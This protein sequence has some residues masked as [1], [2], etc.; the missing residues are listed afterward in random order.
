VHHKTDTTV[1]LALLLLG[2]VAGVGFFSIPVDRENRSMRSTH[3][4]QAAAEALRDKTFGDEQP[5]VFML[6]PL[7]PGLI[8]PTDDPDV[9]PWIEKIR[10]LAWVK[11]ASVLPQSDAQAFYL[12]VLIRGAEE[13]RYFDRVQGT[14]DYAWNHRP[15]GYHLH[16]TGQALGEM[17]ISRAMDEE[18]DRIIPILLGALFLL[19]LAAY[20]RV[21]LA[22][23]ILASALLSILVLGGIQWVIGMQID[24]I[25]SL[26]PPVLL[27]VG[28]AGSVHLIE[29]F[30]EHRARGQTA[31]E[32]TRRAVRD[33]VRPALLTV[34]TT[35]A[36]FLGLLW[37]LIPAVR[38]FGLLAGFGVA[39]T[40]LLTF[41]WLPAYLRVFGR[42]ASLADLRRRNAGWSH[43]S[44]G[45]ALLL[46]HR[47]RIVALAGT[48]LVL[49]F[50]WQWS[51]IAVD[52]QPLRLLPTHNAF[53]MDTESVA[54]SLG[55]IE[56][57]DV[58]LPS[59][60]KGHP[61]RAYLDL[62]RAMHRE[63]LV[64]DLIGLPETAPTGAVR[65]HVLLR[66]AGTGER[67]RLFTRIEARARDLGWPQAV[68]AGAPVIVARD[69]NGLVD[70]QLE[71]MGF[72]LIFL[73]LA[74]S[75]GFRS[76]KY[77]VLGLIPN[78]VP[79][80]FLYGG[81]AF[82]G[83]PLSEG[84]AMIGSVLL[85][86]TVDDS[87]H[88]LYRY[89]QARHLGSSPLVST[90]RSFRVAG[91]A[92]LITTLVQAFGFLVCIVGSLAS[93]REFAILSSSTMIVALAAD[94]FLLPALLLLSRPRPAL[95]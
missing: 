9:P 47:A 60:L 31:E 43:L 37:S 28:V 93:S 80:I 41:L 38:H 18:V 76:L 67:A 82:V 87:I 36:G 6:K 74:M 20:R 59:G 24:P 65:Q 40:C 25:S 23:G 83:R 1:L 94:V 45:L 53:R 21:V 22:V 78:L 64:A 79:A 5:L 19:L 84:S 88:F 10:G 56:S 8:D 46:R 73:W 90:A 13:G 48:V 34:S 29:A 11:Q 54:Q 58:I 35:I 14:V 85:G 70:S 30:L 86:L 66:P 75:F 16:T 81:L 68:T 32:A 62:C 44:G 89:K 92:L 52:T 42:G 26:L 12:V 77:G 17:A 39:L 57:F 15:A 49:F 2:V 51:G 50:S 71:G 95:P 61:T 4:T 33:L 27:T 72:T 69:A 7:R 55:G 3:S 63:P 91:R